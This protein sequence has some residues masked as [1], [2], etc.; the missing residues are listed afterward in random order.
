MS[1]NDIT[2]CTMGTPLLPSTGGYIITV[3]SRQS[4][5][6]PSFEDD[7][8]YNSVVIYD[9][10]V[11]RAQ[12]QLGYATSVPATVNATPGPAETN[13]PRRGTGKLLPAVPDPRGRCRLLAYTL[14][15]IIFIFP[16]RS[17]S[18]VHH[19]YVI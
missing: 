2:D 5:R 16:S 19:I 11:R 3:E 12:R 18:L 7:Y 4:R 17:R 6:R 10:I 14:I 9:H 13:L 8:R 15:I 1:D